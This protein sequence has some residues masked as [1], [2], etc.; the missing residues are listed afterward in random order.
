[1]G[2]SVW[3]GN[4]NRSLD[5]RGSRALDILRIDQRPSWRRSEAFHWIATFV[6]SWIDAD[7]GDQG[8]PERPAT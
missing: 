1:M 2:H 7:A 6:V 5:R 3:R 8:Q 4:G